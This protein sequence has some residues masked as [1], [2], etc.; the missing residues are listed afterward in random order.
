MLRTLRRALRPPNLIALVALVLAMSTPTLGEPI[1]HTAR[2]LAS[3]VGR[4]FA[5]SRSANST[6]KKAML[7][8][9]KAR[10][11]AR[12]ALA[13]GGAP[14]S[15]GPAGPG[16]PPGP[17]GPQGERG[18]VGTQG[19][20]GS[21]LG[22]SRLTYLQGVG[23]H[24]DDATSTF[25]GDVTLTNP[26]EGVFCYTALPFAVHN[27]VATLGNTGATTPLDVVQVDTP[28]PGVPRN[29][30]GDCPPET[31]AKRGRQADAAVYVRQA[32]IGALHDPP[33]SAV[34]FVLFN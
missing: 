23:W 10:Q 16:G 12:A 25:D 13:K 32:D 20:P 29:L 14:G 8:S 34:I 19:P 27:V 31:N 4:A 1:V 2:S 18:K 24:S 21:A 33:H 9:T 28:D 11:E 3:T 26:S 15:V 6:A 7:N 5:L 17:A 30:E 22:Y